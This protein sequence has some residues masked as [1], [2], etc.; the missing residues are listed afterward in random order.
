[1]QNQLQFLKAIFW[2]TKK[3]S[4]EEVC[5]V[6]AC[7]SL[8]FSENLQADSGFWTNSSTGD[9]NTPANWSSGTVPNGAG[10]GAAFILTPN[11]GTTITSSANITVGQLDVVN[12]LNPIT[13]DFGANTL[14][15]DNAG[16]PATFFAG[17]DI[18]IENAIDI[19]AAGLEFVGSASSSVSLNGLIGGS[20]RLALN[21]VD[22]FV[23]LNSSTNNTYTGNTIINQG[24]LK[25]DGLPNIISVPTPIIQLNTPD[26]QLSFYQ[27]EVLNNPNLISLGGLV[28]FNNV[29]ETVRNFNIFNG[30]LFREGD[31]TSSQSTLSMTGNFSILASGRIS[32]HQL[33]FTVPGSVLFYGLEAS[34]GRGVID[35][36][37]A[38][39]FGGVTNIVF[40]NTLQLSLNSFHLDKDLVFINVNI[41]GGTLIMAGDGIVAFENEP[42]YSSTIPDLTILG[43]TVSIGTEELS[44]RVQG[45]V[46]NIDSAGL[47]NG[48]GSYSGSVQNNGELNPG[49][50]RTVSDLFTVGNY[51]QT[52]DG[53][54]LIKGFVNSNGDRLVDKLTVLNQA[55][56][57]GTLSF[58]PLLGSVF[59][60][61]DEFTILQ[62]ANING[63]FSTVHFNLTPGLQA[64]V[65]YNS[66]TVV[67]QISALCQCP[68]CPLCPVCPSS[69]LPPSHLRGQR[70]NDYCKR[71]A[72]NLLSWQPSPSEDIA[73]YR[74]YRNGK[75]IGTV[76]ASAALSFK[77]SQIK[78]GKCY[79]YAVTAVNDQEEE[80]TAAKLTFP[81]CQ[82]KCAKKC[83]ESV[84]E[85][86]LKGIAKPTQKKKDKNLNRLPDPILNLKK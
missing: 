28:S 18:T 60:A 67:I 62:A 84:L 69:L 58:D 2:K 3:K 65:I 1:M 53:T 76:N 55:N 50:A 74:I 12:T 68:E 9:W 40:N 39:V 78:R 85:G 52:S 32:L 61:G 31:N 6:L 48:F 70:L 81:R 10:E 27:S 45:T 72:I 22:A 43:G 36:S 35:G 51:T 38:F 7:F 47:L 75:R 30:G 34:Q 66:Q 11:S 25:L 86:L 21:S 42:G 16:N 73:T 8:I 33:E 59:E 19:G 82:K 63:T 57:N 64:E 71:E 49:N 20:G 26:A 77:D 29:T 37:S 23:T 46:I 54:L 80:S 13:F 5:L 41:S 4:L 14:S 15:F 24:L 17:S 56:L 44:A 79:H 83:S